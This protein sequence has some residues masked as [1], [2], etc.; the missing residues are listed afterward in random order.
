MPLDEY[1]LP[2]TWIVREFLIGRH[3]C[4]SRCL[5]KSGKTEGDGRKR[6]AGFET[7]YSKTIAMQRPEQVLI[8]VLE[9][10]R[11]AGGGLVE[12]ENTAVFDKKKTASGRSV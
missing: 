1:T 2:I 12:T 5:A 11:I 9:R 7:R 6:A 3:G 8:S 4:D 10:E